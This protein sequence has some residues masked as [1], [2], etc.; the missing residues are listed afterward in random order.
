MP[1]AAL[2]R[3]DAK[4]C[5]TRLQTG[6]T[7]SQRGAA[8][9]A[10]APKWCAVR[11]HMPSKPAWLLVRAFGTPCAEC[12]SSLARDGLLRRRLQGG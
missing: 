12:R 6:Y 9:S 4:K 7:L 10:C 8:S 1:R 11:A 5:D 3:G 2:Y